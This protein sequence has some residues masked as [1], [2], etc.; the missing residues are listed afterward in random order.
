MMFMQNLAKQTSISDG[1]NHMKSLAALWP[2]QVDSVVPPPLILD[3]YQCHVSYHIT[4]SAGSA[5]RPQTE[6]ECR[7]ISLQFKKHLKKILP[8]KNPEKGYGGESKRVFQ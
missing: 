8:P 6:Q 1:N 7:T 4:P 5:K 2:M 3:I